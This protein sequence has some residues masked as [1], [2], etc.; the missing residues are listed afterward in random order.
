MKLVRLSAVFAFGALTTAPF[1]F[2]VSGCSS[3]TTPGPSSVADGAV[4]GPAETG[5][6]TSTQGGPCGGNTA[7]PCACVAG[8]VCTAGDSGLPVGDVGGTCE[9]PPDATVTDDA[10]ACVSSQGGRCGGNTTHPCTCT[11]G[12]VCTA[13]DGGGAFGD[14]GGTCQPPPDA[15]ASDDA[16]ACVS[17]QGERCGGN[18]A[19]PCICT[20]GL[21]CIPGDGGGVF[22]DVG[23]TCQPPAD[24]GA[25]AGAAC[26]LTGDCAAGLLCCYSC[27]PSVSGCPNTCTVPQMGH[28]P[29]LP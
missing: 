28:C 4:D 9:P 24:G 20:S 18:T 27:A 12:L 1:L 7:N 23:G 14:V 6:C 11:S 3:G 17:G 8:L 16:G 21:V 13:G 15:T 29:L 26:T 22:G 2:G 5:A 19:H 10:S 25:E